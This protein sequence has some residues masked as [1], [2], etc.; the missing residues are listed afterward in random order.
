MDFFPG[1][2]FFFAFG[3]KQSIFL[4]TSR[5]Q[6]FLSILA[7]HIVAAEGQTNKFF[8][9]GSKTNY[10]FLQKLETNFFFQKNP[11]RKQGFV[12]SKDYWPVISCRI[13]IISTQ[14]L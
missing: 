8:S 5:K 1:Q 11:F 13:Q 14:C 10:F 2:T 4:A 12:E 3:E 6:F 9:S 7:L